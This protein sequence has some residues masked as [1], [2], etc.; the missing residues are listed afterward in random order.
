MEEFFKKILRIIIS[1]AIFIHC[2]I[3]Y[4][5]KVIGKENIPKNEPLLFCG[6]HKSYLDA[7]LI[8]VTAGRRISF[9]AKDE[10]KS[11]VG[12]RILCYAYDG[13]WVKRDHKDIGPLKTALKL[14][15]NGGCVGIFPEGTRNGLE[16]NEGKLKNGASYM[17]IKTGAKIIPIGIIGEAKPFTKNTIIYGKPLDFSKYA[18]SKI[19]KDVEIK[20]SEELKQS[21]IMLT[22]PK[23]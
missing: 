19:D 11:N 22:N 21:I 13:I 8:I 2:K 4:R 10:L 16:K 12:M 14:L 23:K 6:N 5:I 20:A 1:T 9:M 18:E 3:V 15:K 17:A 7:P